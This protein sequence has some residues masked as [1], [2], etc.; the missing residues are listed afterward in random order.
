MNI[1]N[2]RK[3]NSAAVTVVARFAAVIITV[4]LTLTFAGCGNG[5][6]EEG[7]APSDELRAE[8]EDAAGTLFRNN[9]EVFRLFNTIEFDFEGL[10]HFERE[11]YDSV[12]A[13]GFFTLREEVLGSAAFP[14][15][16]VDE[17][18]ALVRETYV[19]TVAESIIDGGIYKERNGSVGVRADFR[20]VAGSAQ[21]GELT[22]NLTIVSDV[23]ALFEQNGKTTQM[24]KTDNGWRLEELMG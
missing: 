2:K 11:P 23:Q 8:V 14:Y 21:T 9:A 20:P 19:E 3:K 17:I 13:D 7:F 1:R 5:V 15:T 12:P 6:Q 4:A 22:V 18:F 16:S 24:L 10:T